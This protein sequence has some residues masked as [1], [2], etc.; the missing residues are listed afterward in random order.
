MVQFY[1][2]ETALQKIESQILKG[3][4]LHECLANY[5]VF[6]KQMVSLIKVAEEVNQ[7][8]KM[9]GKLASQYTL[10]VEHQTSTMSSL[11]EPVMILF[12]G[13]LVAIIL[14]AIYLPLFQMGSTIG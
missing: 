3:K 14:I 9:F 12:L 5:P 13:A 8:D 2:I 10:E 7:L 4:N 6:N 1:P 11:I